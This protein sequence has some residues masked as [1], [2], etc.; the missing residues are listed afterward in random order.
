MA[1]YDKCTGCGLCSEAC[2]VSM[3]LGELSSPEEKLKSCS[4]VMEGNYSF[5]DVENIF[6]CTKCQAC[7]EVC[8][9]DINI[10]AAIDDARERCVLERGVRFAQQRQVIKNAVKYG[11]PFGK[12]GSRISFLEGDYPE[13]SDTLLFIGCFSSYMTK[14]VAR[15]S[16]SLLRKLSVDFSMLGEDE[17]CCGYFIYNTGDHK[18]AQEMVDR[19][20]K[21]FQERAKRII[22]IC[23]GCTTFL[24]KYYH[25]DMEVEH[26]T[27]VISRIIQD[28]GITLEESGEEVTFHD[29]CNIGRS[30][31][32][33]QPPRDIAL[34]MG[35][36]LTEME[37]S[38]EKAIC[39]GADGG[40]KL[41]FPDLALKVGKARLEGVP[42][43]IDKLI[44]VC[45]F[46][47]QNLKEASLKYGMGV[48][49]LHLLELLD[50]KL[51][52]TQTSSSSIP[53][54]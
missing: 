54:S 4:K 24:K 41:S 44:T 28:K 14:G 13:T 29:A 16:V 23:P 5:K 40:M 50:S 42:H 3:V 43:G 37:R 51:K 27:E 18:T 49:V 45:P 53:R 2:S 39:C 46:C 7:E 38:R 33:Y 1:E 30:L 48:E 26:I 11:S 10:T 35:Y 52:A 31:Q 6:Q 47:L 20:R 22:T 8:P 36:R 9:Q 17:P 21:L 15:A 19:N 32:I 25:L 34:S 12:A